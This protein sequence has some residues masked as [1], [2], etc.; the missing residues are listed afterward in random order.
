MPSLRGIVLASGPALLPLAANAMASEPRLFAP[1][2]TLLAPEVAARQAVEL[3]IDHVLGRTAIVP[4][5]AEELQLKGFKV[6]DKPPDVIFG[7]FTTGVIVLNTTGKIRVIGHPYGGCHVTTSDTPTGPIA[8]EF[9][10]LFTEITFSP[11]RR[12]GDTRWRQWRWPLVGVWH[13][14]I[15]M[16]VTPK[17]R[18]GHG[19]VMVGLQTIAGKVPQ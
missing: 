9:A 1:A 19:L 4:G 6:E 18:S 8:A 10:K 5:A 3:C 15:G 11:G 2:T 17:L 16:T 7:P 12:L 14:N 13:V